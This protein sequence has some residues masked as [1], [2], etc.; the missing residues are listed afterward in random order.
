[1]ISPP[2]DGISYFASHHSGCSATVSAAAA[3]AAVLP[4]AVRSGR[5][6]SSGGDNFRSR[7]GA[8]V[9]SSSASPFAPAHLRCR[10]LLK[11][12]NLQKHTALLPALESGLR[13]PLR[14]IPIDCHAPAPESG[15]RSGYRSEMAVVFGPKRT[16]IPIVDQ[17]LTVASLG[18]I[19][20]GLGE[21]HL[22][23]YAL[24]GAALRVNRT[25]ISPC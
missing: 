14:A 13:W 12:I 1:M 4:S 15:R 20:I 25:L 9:L 21:G 22:S 23:A 17:Q 5:C 3:S 16:A 10:A 11:L 18:N 7:N 24:S 19:A 8:E 6:G 2:C